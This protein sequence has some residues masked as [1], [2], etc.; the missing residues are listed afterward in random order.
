M[1]KC[2]EELIVVSEQ[3]NRET[4]TSFAAAALEAYLGKSSAAG[5]KHIH[6]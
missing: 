1:H 5:F 4:K 2:D 6:N 3:E